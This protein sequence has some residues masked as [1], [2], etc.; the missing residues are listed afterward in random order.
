MG[1]LAA[2]PDVGRNKTDGDT[3]YENDG[4]KSPIW[5]SSF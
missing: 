5:D 2:D 4:T 3:R 1:W